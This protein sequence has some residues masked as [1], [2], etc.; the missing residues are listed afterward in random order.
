MGWNDQV[1]VTAGGGATGIIKRCVGSVAQRA[2]GNAS[3]RSLALRLRWKWMAR[4]A[5][6]WQ[7]GDGSCQGTVPM[8]HAD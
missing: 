2:E 8:P 7:H 4:S 5:A 6:V 3:R 1:D